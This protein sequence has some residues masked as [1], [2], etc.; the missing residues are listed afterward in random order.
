MKTLFSALAIIILAIFSSCS[1]SKDIPYTKANGYFV[2]NTVQFV[3][4]TPITSQ[5][6]F[7]QYFGMATVMGKDGRP[8]E[9]DFSKQFVLAVTTPE[10]N[11]ATEITPESLRKSDNGNLVFTYRI[12]QGEK[13]SYSTHPCLILIVSDKYKG[14][15]E[16][17]IH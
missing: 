9:I 10:T 14:E 8:T 7:D 15:V 3:P 17:R 5:E 1:S 11:I 6:Q 16:Y 4:Q 12:V 13:Q 2:N